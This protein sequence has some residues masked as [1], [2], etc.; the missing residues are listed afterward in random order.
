MAYEMLRHF[1]EETQE[2][3]LKIFNKIWVLREY[4]NWNFFYILPFKNTGK[5]G[6]Q[7][8]DYR[9]IALTSCLCKLLEGMVNVLFLWYLEHKGILPPFQFGFRRKRNTI[10]ILVS[11][12]A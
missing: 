9:P 10:D 5:S 8:G 12:E 4:P 7:P 11:L 2:L 6:N 3:L 1:P